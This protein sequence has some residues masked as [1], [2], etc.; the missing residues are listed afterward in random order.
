MEIIKQLSW[1]EETLKP[2][3]FSIHKGSE[4]DLLLEDKRGNLYS[5]EIKT[6][7]SIQKKHFNGLKRLSEIAGDKFKRGVVLYTGEQYLGGFGENMQAVPISKIW[8]QKE[9]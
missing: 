9:D 5:L 6:S 2:Y 7:A 3:H 1:S 4:V 8:E